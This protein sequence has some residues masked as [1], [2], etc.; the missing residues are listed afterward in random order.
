M[1]KKY[2]I[3]VIAAVLAMIGWQIYN[4]G[5]FSTKQPAR[6][7]SLPIAVDV[8][9]VRKAMI[10]DVGN[11]T[12]T[13]L[14]DSKFIVAP[15]I[16]GKLKKVL[17]DIGDEVKRGQLIAVLDGDEFVQQVDQ[18]RAELDVARAN[19]EENRSVLNLAR[20]E[21]ER[22]K[23]L[24]EKK[25]VSE[26]ELDAAEAQYKASI[27]KQKV[28]GA[29]VAQK[30]AELKTAQVR[31]NYTRIRASWENGSEFRIVGERFVD[32]GTMLT[33][34]A[35]IATIIDIHSLKAVIHVIERDYPQMKTGHT[36]RITTDAYPD[37]TFTGTIAR[38]APILEEATRQ[39]RVEFAIPNP[40]KLLKPG[41]FVRVEIE[42]ARHD[43][44]TVVPLNVLTRHN[45]Q[46]GIFLA[47][48]ET[49]MV[50][51]IPVTVG[52]ISGEMAEI[53][54]PPLSGM[55]V[56]VGQHLLEDGSAITLSTAEEDA[57]PPEGSPGNESKKG[58]QP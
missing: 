21:F 31:L 35:P 10:R 23:A 22:A 15:K 41:M 42:F 38:I 27:A 29:Q 12:G 34:N 24:R 51:L 57:L 56:S 25:I 37:K 58:N 32:E 40:M 46:R 53:V 18:A 20:R 39:A 28:A 8:V 50:R 52:I 54:D 4:K 30:E 47:D 1:N 6:H 19:V 45:G 36:A 43:N 7:V 9:P 49:M 3:V 44:A 17:I 11:F 5:F 48:K 13:L 55:V 16:A 26:S 14:P 33:A 2:V